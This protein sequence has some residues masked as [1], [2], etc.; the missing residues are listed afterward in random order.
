MHVHENK[1]DRTCGLHRPSMKVCA[2]EGRGRYTRVGR[3]PYP[4]RGSRMN[5]FIGSSH[6]LGGD[7]AITMR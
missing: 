3:W 7:H 6:A 2:R 1:D 5:E 4:R